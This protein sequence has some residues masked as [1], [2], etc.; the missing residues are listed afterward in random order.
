M[1]ICIP[2]EK[3]GRYFNIYVGKERPCWIY[4][5][6]PGHHAM[7]CRGHYPCGEAVWDWTKAHA[8]KEPTD[9]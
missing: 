9:G 4:G 6:L 5:R 7:P 3:C 8:L 2:C 1:T